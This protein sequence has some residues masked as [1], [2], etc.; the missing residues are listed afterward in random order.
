MGSGRG[1]LHARGLANP[2]D[3]SRPNCS[4]RSVQPKISVGFYAIESR[5]RCAGLWASRACV[6]S[7]EGPSP[8]TAVLGSS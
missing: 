2:D 4:I 8:P 5:K 1:R 6:Q 7:N 3:V